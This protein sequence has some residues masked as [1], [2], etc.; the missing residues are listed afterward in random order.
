MSGA[1]ADDVVV[2]GF[3]LPSDRPISQNERGWIA[4]L[5]LV[6]CDCDPAPTLRFVQAMRLAFEDARVGYG[7]PG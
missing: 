5:R 3:R 7:A 4:L 6:S 1:E 2:T